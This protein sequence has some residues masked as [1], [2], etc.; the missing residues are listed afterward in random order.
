MKSP[1]SDT[2]NFKAY[3]DEEW[4][5]I[6]NVI[7]KLDL[8]ADKLRVG[9]SDT[10]LREALE[11]LAVRFLLN[12]IIARWR[13]PRKDLRATLDAIEDIQRRLDIF[14]GPIGNYA[15]NEAI[16]ARKALQ[17]F[18]IAAELEQRLDAGGSRHNAAKPQQRAHLIEL[19]RIWQQ[20]VS[21]QP[22]APQRKLKAEFLLACAGPSFG[23][24]AIGVR[25]FL[26]RQT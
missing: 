24:N 14:T 18:V 13:P 19:E 7:A 3:S 12:K 26:D 8:D 2:K 6:K 9:V 11:G 20:L 17:K 16:A 5:R 21:R 23:V 22:R 25:N 4:Q 10:P 1:S 15:P